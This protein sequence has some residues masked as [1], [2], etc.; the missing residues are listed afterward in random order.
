MVSSDGV[1]L[2]VSDGI[3]PGHLAQLAAITSGLVGLAAAAA[4][5]FEGGRVIQTLVAMSRAR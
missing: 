2:A 4:C 1:P 3:P 5:V